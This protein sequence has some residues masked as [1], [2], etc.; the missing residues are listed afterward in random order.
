MD[1]KQD[2]MIQEFLDDRSL[3]KTSERR[4][5]ITLQ[6]YSNF[7]KLSPEQLIKSEQD[8]KKGL[9]LRE[10]RIKRHLN[11]FKAY[12]LENGLIG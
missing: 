8:E 5:L 1:I 9:L 7:T 11:G 10:R 4:Y 12:L 3:A 6:H 2:P